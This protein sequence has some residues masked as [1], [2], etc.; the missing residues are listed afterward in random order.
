MASMQ[1]LHYFLAETDW[2]ERTVMQEKYRA[3]RYQG[4][5]VV[6]VDLELFWPQ[7]LVFWCTR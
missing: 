5:A 1:M 7:V 3:D 2:N 4:M 6:V